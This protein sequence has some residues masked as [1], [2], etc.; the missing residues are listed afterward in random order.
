MMLKRFL[1][2]IP[3]SLLT[4]LSAG[5]YAAEVRVD[6]RGKS[7]EAI[8]ASLSKAA[9]QACHKDFRG[10]P[11]TWTFVEQCARKS[12]ARAVE[13]TGSPAVV[14]VHEGRPAAARVVASR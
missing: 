4:L 13:A 14:A 7:P 2:V 3:A 11:I 6:L 9:W 8:H 10:N 5:A 1:A 12:L